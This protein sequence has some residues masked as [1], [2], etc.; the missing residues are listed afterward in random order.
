VIGVLCGAL[1]ALGCDRE[2]A[3]HADPS[4]RAEAVAQVN[5]EPVSVADVAAHAG[6]T[7]LS[8]KEALAQIVADRL[9]IQHAEAGGYGALPAVERAVTQARVRALL[10]DEIERTV[11]ADDVQGRARRLDALLAEIARRTPVRFVDA[12]VQV[13]LTEP[14]R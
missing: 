12:G 4:A 6:A 1:L 10:A 8:P 2:A 13:A 9:L 3:L 14:F 11:P 7:G 5:G